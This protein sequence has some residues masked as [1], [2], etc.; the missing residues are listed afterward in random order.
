MN[1]HEHHSERMTF[2]EL[3][4]H[5]LTNHPEA[6]RAGEQTYPRLSAVHHDD[7]LRVIRETLALAGQRVS[8]VVVDGMPTEPQEI[9]RTGNVNI[10]GPPLSVRSAPIA[11]SE[12]DTVS[13]TH[14]E[15]IDIDSPAP[16]ERANTLPNR[17]WQRMAK[18]Q[19]AYNLL[20]EALQEAA[21]EASTQDI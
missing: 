17:A 10:M 15:V 18:I 6:P 8:N 1:P 19:A 9:D 4:E 3:Q 16:T 11:P 14:E 5:L 2:A 20:G 7:H 21:T 13:I 12:G